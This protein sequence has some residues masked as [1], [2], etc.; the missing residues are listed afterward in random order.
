MSSYLPERFQ[1]PFGLAARLFKSALL[2]RS[3]ALSRSYARG[4]YRRSK[5]S[6]APSPIRTTPVTFV[7]KARTRDPRPLRPSLATTWPYA[8]SQTSSMTSNVATMRTSRV[9]GSPGSVNWGITVTKNAPVFGLTRL[10]TRP[11]LQALR[12]RNVAPRGACDSYRGDFAR[13]LLAP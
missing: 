8:T 7:M 1:L 11:W 3:L 4:G 6:L 13:R 10:L 5:A 2:E 12:S 9:A